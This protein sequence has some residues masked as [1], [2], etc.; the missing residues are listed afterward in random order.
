M[1]KDR[2]SILS[3][4]NLSLKEGL[5]FEWENSRKYK[6]HAEGLKGVFSIGLGRHG[7]FEDI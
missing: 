7:H 3:Q 4:N 6:I 2:K 5:Y 1:L